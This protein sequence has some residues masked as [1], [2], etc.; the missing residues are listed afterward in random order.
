M[1]VGNQLNL[2]CGM[3]SGHR[4]WLYDLASIC[5]ASIADGPRYLGIDIVLF[6]TRM[7]GCCN[8][9]EANICMYAELVVVDF[10]CSFRGEEG[11]LALRPYLMSITH[12]V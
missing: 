3:S 2:S 8:R 5:S 11:L 10:V 12:Y 1:S 6:Q 7:D 9:P 4:I